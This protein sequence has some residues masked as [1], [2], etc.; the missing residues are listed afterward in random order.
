MVKSKIRT[1]GQIIKL[2]RGTY[3]AAK[4]KEEVNGNKI[5]SVQG[6]TKTEEFKTIKSSLRFIGK[7]K[8]RYY[9]TK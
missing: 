9:K 8:K 2:P 4:G 6:T 3:I 5:T 7:P 1:W